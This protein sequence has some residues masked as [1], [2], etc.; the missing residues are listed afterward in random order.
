MAGLWDI[1]SLAI[2]SYFYFHKQIK[3]IKTV[4]VVKKLCEIVGLFDTLLVVGH[5][6]NDKDSGH[7]L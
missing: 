3:Q 2:W 4:L 7:T 1:W 5:S 6:Y